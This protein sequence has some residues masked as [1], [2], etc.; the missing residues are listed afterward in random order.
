MLSVLDISHLSPRQNNKY[1]INICLIPMYVK[2]SSDMLKK[3]IN[4]YTD[5]IMIDNLFYVLCP[6]FDKFIFI[7]FKKTY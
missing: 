4:W 5:L 6:K 2:L 7:L 1:A 3:Q